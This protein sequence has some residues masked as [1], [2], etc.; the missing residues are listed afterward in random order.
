MENDFEIIKTIK[1]LNFDA[2]Y[3]V[4]EKK[5]RKYV[6]LKNIQKNQKNQKK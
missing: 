5:P 4:K 2:I 3:I 1:N 6:V